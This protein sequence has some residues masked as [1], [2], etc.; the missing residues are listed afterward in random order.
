MQ[1]IGPKKDPARNTPC[2][3]WW[4]RRREEL[5]SLAGKQTPVLVY[6]EESLNHQLIEPT[7]LKVLERKYIGEKYYFENDIHKRMAFIV[8]VGKRRL[9]L[10][11]FF[12]NISN[13]FMEES[14]DFTSL[15]KPYLAI[16]ALKKDL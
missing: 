15:K 5:F 8:G 2:A 10:G 6:D 12:K 14:M 9:L 7:G 4:Q 3:A 1:L 16:L 13:F 11:R